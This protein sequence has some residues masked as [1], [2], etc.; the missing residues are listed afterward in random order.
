MKMFARAG[1]GSDGCYVVARAAVLRGVQA[2][3]PRY[4]FPPVSLLVI[5]LIIAAG[6]FFTLT[7]VINVL[8][9]VIIW[10]RHS[11]C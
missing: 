9:A 3:A 11:A 6:S 10:V 4:D 7:T 5:G 2:A 1:I 8:V